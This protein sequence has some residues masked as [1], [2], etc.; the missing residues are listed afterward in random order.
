MVDCNPVVITMNQITTGAILQSA[1]VSEAYEHITTE[2]TKLVK[3]LPKPRESSQNI[4]DNLAA[5]ASQYRLGERHWSR[6]FHAVQE[7]LR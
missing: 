3:K 1:T 4:A 6:R 2:G 5:D 7:A